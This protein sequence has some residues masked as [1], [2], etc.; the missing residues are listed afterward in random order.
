M[1]TECVCLL[2]GLL[3]SNQAKPFLP[4]YKAVRPPFRAVKRKKSEDTSNYQVAKPVVTL[5][6]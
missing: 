2:E 4:L 1:K 5:P 3:V 6:D